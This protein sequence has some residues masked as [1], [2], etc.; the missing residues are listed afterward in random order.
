M[1]PK[2]ANGNAGSFTAVNVATGRTMWK[3]DQRAAFPGSVLT[4][5][6][7][8]V[9]VTDDNRRLRAFNAKTGDVLWE[10]VLHSRAGGFPITYQVDG[11]QYIAVPAGT[12]LSYVPVTPE[13]KVPAGGNVLYVFALPEKTKPRVR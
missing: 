5:G 8:L 9:F 4:T 3:F 11:R 13:I 10:Q 1:I 12:G 7:N 6:G 2:S